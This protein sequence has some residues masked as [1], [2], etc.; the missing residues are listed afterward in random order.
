VVDNVDPLGRRRL[1][2]QVP[3]VTAA[4]TWAEAC[5]PAGSRAKPAIDSGVWVQF[6]NGDARYP[7]WVGIRP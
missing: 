4:P 5:V 6:E 3:D 1:R 7:V 2:V